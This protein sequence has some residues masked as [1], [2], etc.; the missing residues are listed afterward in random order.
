MGLWEALVLQKVQDLSSLFEAVVGVV[1]CLG[2]VL[3]HDRK[4]FREVAW[5]VH[6]LHVLLDGR[7]RLIL[8]IVGVVFEVAEA[9]WVATDSF[10]VVHVVLFFVFAVENELVE[11][12]RLVEVVF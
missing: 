5:T 7:V 3:A 2:K 9:L 1:N 4:V 6:D 10:V 12:D 8:A 11:H